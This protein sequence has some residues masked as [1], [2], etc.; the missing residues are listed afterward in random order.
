MYSHFYRFLQSLILKKSFS[1]DLIKLIKKHK[2]SEII[3]IGSADSPILE[4]MN[5]T[6][7]YHGYELNSYF[8]NKLKF[9]YKN[10]NKFHFYNKGVDEID[11]KKFDPDKSIIILIGLFHHIEDTQIYRFINKTKNFK[12][13][14]IDAVKLP[15]QKNITKFLMSLDKGN[16]IRQLDGYKKILLN[17]D[18][19]ITKNRYLRFS[20]DHLI[21]TNNI[22]KNIINDVFK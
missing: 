13:F 12:I 9:K 21:S 3:D 7:S 2:V 5:D 4:Y 15:G 20:Y 6:Y 17:F 18:F 8:T 1:E 16:Y 22:D 11:F 14:A 19:L 10:N